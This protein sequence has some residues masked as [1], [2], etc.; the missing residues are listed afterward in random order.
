[1]NPR[2]TQESSIQNAPHAPPSAKKNELIVVDFFRVLIRGRVWISKGRTQVEIP[3]YHPH[4]GHARHDGPRSDRLKPR[5]IRSAPV[6]VG[7]STLVS[8]T[9]IP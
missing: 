2:M 7:F 3:A 9:P 1:M 5:L 6:G 8:S 4:D